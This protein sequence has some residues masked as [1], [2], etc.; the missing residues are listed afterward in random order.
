MKILSFNIAIKIDN[1]KEVSNFIKKQKIDIIGFQEILRN[2]DENTFEEYKSEEKIKNNIKK[3]LKYDFFW[4]MWIANAIVINWKKVI[5]FNGFVE[6][7]NQI[8]SKYP[9]ISTSN[10]FFYKNYCMKFDWTDFKEN[11]HPRAVQIVELKIENK[12]LQIINIHWTYSK[13][14]LDS[15]RSTK[16]IEKIIKIIERKNIPTIILWDFNLFPETEWIKIL[17][18]KFKNLIF[19]N[20]IKSTRPEFKDNLD[21]W[22]NIVDYIFV[23]DK[24]KVNTFEVINTD[25]SDHLPLILDFDIK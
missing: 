20:N 22:N 24:I 16:Q 8:F 1:S 9:I 2:F 3:Y 14:K 10:E 13:N 15:K 25:I 18:S 6:Q 23:N 5:D 17:S 4:P 11:D 12:I 21:E 19:E 7:W